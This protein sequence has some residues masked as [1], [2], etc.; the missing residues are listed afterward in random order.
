[1][2]KTT[3]IA[4]FQQL[5]AAVTACGGVVPDRIGRLLSAHRLLST[6][7][8]ADPPEKA[9]LTA[10][11]KGELDEKSLAKMLPAAA[12]AEIV[13]AYRAELAHRAEH[14]IVGQLH[15]ELTAQCANEIL[16]SLRGNFDKHAAAL[17]KAR[18]LGISAESS[19]EH[20]LATGEPGLVEAWNSLNEHI[21]A[22][23]K[24]GAIA[25]GFGPRMGGFPQLREYPGGENFR[26]VDAAIMCTDGSLLVESSWF[27]S[28]NQG[29]R[30]SPWA[31]CT[32]KLHSI[33]SA[34]A[35][36]NE[37]AAG[38]FDRINDRDLG[39]RLDLATGVVTPHP[40]PKNPYRKS[41]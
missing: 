3:N 40:R 31:R 26:L 39:G 18:S 15:R 23:S 22:V 20:I 35:R 36:Y 41:A 37:F 30:T 32:L 7:G 19:P 10:A 21:A 8:A 13:N 25:I 11:L 29:H 1:M 33:A 4:D 28:P 2:P 27:Q 17:A 34:T 14:V 9:I 12:S 16:D 5:A 38:E 24:I 6:P